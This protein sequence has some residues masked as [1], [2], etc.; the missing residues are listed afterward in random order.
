MVNDQDLKF[1]R[2][3]LSELEDFIDR[4]DKEAQRLNLESSLVYQEVV[5]GFEVLK[6]SIMEKIEELEE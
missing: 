3:T 6:E 2:N 5:D 4:I 1:L